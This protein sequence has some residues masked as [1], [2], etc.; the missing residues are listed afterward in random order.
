MRRFATDEEI[1]RD[2]RFAQH[3]AVESSVR[4]AR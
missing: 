4:P 1:D 3:V 2:G